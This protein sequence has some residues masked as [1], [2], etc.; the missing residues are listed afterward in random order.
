MPYMTLPWLTIINNKVA[1]VITITSTII[2]IGIHDVSV[3]FKSIAD[4]AP[5]WE[6]IGS[7]LGIHGNTLTAISNNNSASADKY[8]I[9]MVT[10]WL[11]RNYDTS[12]HGLPTW[13]RLVQVIASP[14]GGNNATLALTIARQHNMSIHVHVAQTDHASQQ[15]RPYSSLLPDTDQDISTISPSYIDTNVISTG[16]VIGGPLSPMTQTDSSHPCDEAES[17][18]DLPSHYIKKPVQKTMT[19]EM[20][21]LYELVDELN[22]E[23]ATNIYETKKCL[24]EYAN[25]SDVQDYVITHVSSLINTDSKTKEL[26]RQSLME[27]TTFEQLFGKLT[28]YTSWY[29]YDLIVN[30]SRQF[31]R[32]SHKVRRKWRSYE[33]KLKQ[34]LTLDVGVTEYYDPVEFGEHKNGDRKVFAVKVPNENLVKNDL[35]FFHKA[36]A[37]SLKQTKFSLYFC[38]IHR[39]CLELKYLI[40]KYLHLDISNALPQAMKE[41]LPQLGI[42]EVHWNGK[43]IILDKVSCTMPRK[44]SFIISFRYQ[45]LCYFPPVS[46]INL[47]KVINKH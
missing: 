27:A 11:Q 39:G 42:G 25:F 32:H 35:I 21:Y 38:S 7:L 14:A 24:K 33:D 26:L 3:V 23:Y 12:H 9:D 44:N 41:Y 4:V 46:W 2:H 18:M 43:K 19:S 22:Q 17:K 1:I 28:N 37:K 6:P 30:L 29:N 34:Y 31:L 47:L 15:S 45:I 5:N 16:L 40:P 36:L 10:C 13:E 20:L 8:L